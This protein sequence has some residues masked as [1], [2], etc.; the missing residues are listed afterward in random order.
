MYDI[1]NLIDFVVEFL[2]SVL[3]RLSFDDTS[4]LLDELVVYA[5]D[6]QQELAEYANGLCE[7]ESVDEEEEDRTEEYETADAELKRN[8]RDAWLAQHKDLM[9]SQSK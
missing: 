5:D 1:D 8:L 6:K 2:D 9:T 3:S 4:V 7:D